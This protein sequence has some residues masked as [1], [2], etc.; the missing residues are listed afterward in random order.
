[1]ETQRFHPIT[2]SPHHIE[3]I[4]NIICQTRIY[5]HWTGKKAWDKI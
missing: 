3:V 5:S 4:I 1:M 2:T